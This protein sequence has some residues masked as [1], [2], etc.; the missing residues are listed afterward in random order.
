MIYTLLGLILGGCLLIFVVLPFLIRND[1]KI[2]AWY[3]RNF[4]D[5]K[6][7]NK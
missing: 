2:E 5:R 7:K 4:I 6:K 3:D 1:D